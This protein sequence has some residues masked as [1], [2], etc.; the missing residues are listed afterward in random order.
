M[1]QF[2]SGIFQALEGGILIF[3]LLFMLQLIFECT[4]HGKLSM[5]G[6]ES[7]S[8]ASI[9]EKLKILTGVDVVRCE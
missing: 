2:E 5:C 8:V 6:K 4:G 7:T 3:I 9:T 1:N